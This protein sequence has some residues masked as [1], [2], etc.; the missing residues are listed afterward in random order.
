MSKLPLSFASVRFRGFVKIRADRELNEVRKKINSVLGI[1]LKWDDSGYFEEF[2]AAVCLLLGVRFNL[3]GIPEDDHITNSRQ[4]EWYTLS[5]MDYNT[6]D[7]NFEVNLSPNM[8]YLLKEESDLQC[9]EGEWTEGMLMD[10][11]KNR[12]DMTN[13]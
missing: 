6:F 8:V 11:C 7:H 5:L 4:R 3:L 2:P 1:N 13:E 10:N 12:L 9:E